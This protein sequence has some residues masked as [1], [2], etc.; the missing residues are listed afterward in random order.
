VRYRAVIEAQAFLGMPKVASND[1]GELPK[2]RAHAFFK[3]IEVVQRNVPH[4]G[5]AL[6]EPVDE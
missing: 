4:V 6:N 3:R 2:F 1:V 5:S